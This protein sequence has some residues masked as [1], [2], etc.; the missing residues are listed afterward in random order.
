MT[1]DVE[2]IAIREMAEYETT[3]L[4]IIRNDP[5]ISPSLHSSPRRSAGRGGEGIRVK[6]TFAVRR[7]LFIYWHLHLMPCDENIK[8]RNR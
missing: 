5:A 8:R 3:A 2:S 6:A 1:V 4:P 7:I